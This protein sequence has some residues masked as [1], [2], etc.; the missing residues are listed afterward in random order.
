MCVFEI[1][2]NAHVQL[3]PRNIW[4][5]TQVLA[6]YQNVFKVQLYNQYWLNG[7]ILSS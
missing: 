1:N 4:T 3:V 2:F 7:Q 6:F 5:V